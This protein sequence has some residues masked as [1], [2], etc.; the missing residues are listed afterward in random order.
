[1]TTLLALYRGDTV[2]SAKLVAVTAEP[3]LCA[4][5]AQRLL[6]ETAPEAEPDPVLEQVVA[7]RR[8]ALRL[9]AREEGEAVAR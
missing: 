4:E 7:G 8:G 2:A 3:R 6:T 9:I 1:M 5:F